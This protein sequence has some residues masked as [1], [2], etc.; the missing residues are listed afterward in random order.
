LYN[1]ICINKVEKTKKNRRK[2]N[3]KV[4]EIEKKK[5]KQ[6]NWGMRK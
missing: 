6:S 2:G 1:R 4:R 5:I 3:E